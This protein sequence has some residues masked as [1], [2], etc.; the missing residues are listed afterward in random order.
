MVGLHA[1]KGV[2]EH[3]AALEVNGTL[4]GNDAAG[5]GTSRPESV[6]HLAPWRLGVGAEGAGAVLA[7]D[8]TRSDSR[9][10][11]IDDTA[12]VCA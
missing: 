12:G 6:S 3:A 2:N 7:D 10:S 8:K 11:E 5:N 4:L 9:K 1:L